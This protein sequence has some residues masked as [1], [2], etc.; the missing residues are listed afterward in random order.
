MLGG[1][2]DN[3]GYEWF[4]EWIIGDNKTFEASPCD[5]GKACLYLTLPRRQDREIEAQYLRCLPHMFE[6]SDGA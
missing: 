2:H 3:P 4:E 5:R 1:E 6:L